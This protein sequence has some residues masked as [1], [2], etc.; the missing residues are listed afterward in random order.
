MLYKEKKIVSDSKSL[1]SVSLK[2]PWTENYLQ[3]WTAE[4]M[5]SISD[6][7]IGISP[8]FCFM[9]IIEVV[10]TR[11][12]SIPMPKTDYL[13]L[14]YHQDHQFELRKTRKL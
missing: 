9:H 10:T 11:L 7:L 6:S 4:W 3:M 1:K 5:D 13:K 8:R 12:H 2:F 14:N